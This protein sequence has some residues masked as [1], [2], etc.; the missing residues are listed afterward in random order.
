MSVVADAVQN[1]GAG[2]TITALP[3]SVPSHVQ[4]HRG[5]I[6]ACRWS[7]TV[8]HSDSDRSVFAYTPPPLSLLNPQLFFGTFHSRP[9]P[10]G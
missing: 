8:H 6:R 10:A 9:S 1:A 3:A 4:G 7:S 5:K 2:H